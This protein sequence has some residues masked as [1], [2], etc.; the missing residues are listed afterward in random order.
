MA[1]EIKIVIKNADQMRT[2]FRQAPALMTKNINTSIRK[3]I[4]FIREK[5]VSNAPA[6]TGRLRS[7]A[8]TSFSPLQGEVGFL[9]NYALFVHEGTKAHIIY[10]T[11][12]KA[13]F[14]K[15]ASHPVKRVNHPGTRANPF[16]RRAVDMGEQQIDK[17]FQ[18]GVDD[19]L[20]QIAKDSA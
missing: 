2:A 1:V 5:S 9:A 13:L 17:F 8:Y 11:S 6:K 15:G 10:P 16:L 20:R 3:T 4:M 12:K 7:S 19:T 18:Q 14:W